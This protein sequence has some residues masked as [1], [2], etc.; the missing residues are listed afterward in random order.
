[1]RVSRI[2]AGIAASVALV[3]PA[4]L[5][6]GPASATPHAPCVIGPEEDHCIYWGQSYSGS[7]SGVPEEV[8]NFPVSGATPYIYLAAG[9]GQGE[10]IGNNNGSDQNLDTTCEVTLWYDPNFAGP[11]VTLTS[12][13]LSGHQRAGSQLGTLLNNIRSQD[14]AC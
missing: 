6:G 9:S 12:Y 13:P 4:V 8:A 11:S 2:A 14:W 7:H 3:A 1:M 10:R 5:I